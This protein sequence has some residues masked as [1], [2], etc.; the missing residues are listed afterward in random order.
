MPS[1]ANPSAA[2]R[3]PKSTLDPASVKS[4]P[5]AADRAGP[6]GRTWTARAIAAPAAVPILVPTSR[7]RARRAGGT[8][9]IQSVRPLSN[10]TANRSSCQPGPLGPLSNPGGE[11]YPVDVTTGT[12]RLSITAAGA[13]SAFAAASSTCPNSPPAVV[14][15]A[16]NRSSSVP[17]RY[18]SPR[19]SVRSR[20]ISP[21]NSGTGA[22]AV[23]I[24]SGDA[25]GAGPSTT[26]PT[27][28]CPANSRRRGGNATAE[29]A[30]TRC[31]SKTSSP[32][33]NIGSIGTVARAVNAQLSSR[34][35][36]LGGA[37]SA[38]VRRIP[39]LPLPADA[40]RSRGSQASRSRR[41]ISAIAERLL[42]EHHLSTR[43][44]GAGAELAG[45]IHAGSIGTG[46]YQPNI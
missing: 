2:V 14:R 12:P 27:T 3:T 40:T 35:R 18:S 22:L 23:K 32:P 30:S 28:P 1:L 34:S 25:T 26:T 45:H 37:A 44:S 11:A 31:G 6:R 15:S 24:G 19:R 8:G 7:A 39:A 42:S 20:L 4:A 29:S 41:V 9:P 36:P 43:R 38:G 46:G 10:G 16:R 5:R 21:S 17:A 33:R 13:A